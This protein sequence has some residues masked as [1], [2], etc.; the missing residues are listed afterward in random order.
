MV[1][2]VLEP[3]RAAGLVPTIFADTVSDP[4]DIVIETGAAALKRAVMTA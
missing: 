3:L 1:E 2:Q 4:T